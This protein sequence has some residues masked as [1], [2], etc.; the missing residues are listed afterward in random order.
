MEHI[1]YEERVLISKSDYKKIIA[2][3]KKERRQLIKTNITNIYLD[4]DDS[5]IYKTKK[6]LRIRFTN[7]Q[8]IELTL[9]TKFPDNSCREINESLNEHP[10]IDKELEGS[11]SDYHQI[12]KLETK[13]IEV[14]FDDYLLVIDKNKYHG[15]TDYDIEIEADSQE[16][17]R[18]LVLFYCEK[19]N[20]VFDPNYKSKSHRAIT[21]AKELLKK[22][23]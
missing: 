7:H 4:N 18:K 16:K 1:E 2:D 9:K 19:Y 15:V 11:F 8:E 12:A 22:E 17:A 13:R 14:R 3:V 10:L 23:G 6:M 21:K 20:L 5:F